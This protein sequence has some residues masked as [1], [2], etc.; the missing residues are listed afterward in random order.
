MNDFLNLPK[1]VSDIVKEE[2]SRFNKFSIGYILNEY[3]FG[4]S[5]VILHIKGNSIKVVKNERAY[6]ER[7]IVKVR[8]E[9]INQILQYLHSLPEYQS[10]I[11]NLNVIVPIC[12]SD[13]S[14]SPMQKIPCL[15]FSKERYSNNILIPSLN[16]IVG[17]AECDFVNQNDTPLFN[18]ENK[19]CFAASLTNIR[20]NNTGIQNNQR[21]QI[22]NLANNNP[23][24]FFGKI[25]RPPLFDDKEWREVCDSISDTFPG[26]IT[27]DYFSKEVNPITLDQ[28]LKYKYQICFDGHTCAWA[29]LPWQLKSNSVVFKLRNPQNDFV[30]WFYYLLKSG[31]HYIEVELDNLISI[32]NYIKNEPEYQMEL[33]SNATTFANKYLTTYLARRIFLYTLHLLTQHQAGKTQ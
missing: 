13:K 4:P 12:F 22:A 31:K 23:D 27:S 7:N 8:A 3:K 24:L 16:A 1:E 11:N 29:R 2:T 30:E 28:Q 5:D 9:S 6:E 26:L 15:S 32:Y 17:Y 18:K 20:W 10:L 14:D 33:S 25:V 19:M 21:L